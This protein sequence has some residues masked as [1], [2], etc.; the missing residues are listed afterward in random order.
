MSVQDTAREYYNSED[1]DAFYYNIWGGEDIH[2][3]IYFSPDE[4]IRTASRR[5]VERMTAKLTRAI[6]PESHV[7]DMGSGFG[8]A[9]RYLTKTYDCSVTAVNISEVEN[10]RHREMNIEQAVADRIEVIDGSFESVPLEDASV[11]VV[12]S[13]DAI[14][15]SGNR[16]QVVSEVHRVLKPGGEF[17]FTDPMQ[18]DDCPEGV[19]QPILDRIHLDSLASPGYYKQIAEA[20]GLRQLIFEDLT[21]Q[22][23]RHYERVLQETERTADRL[24]GSV[25]PEYIENMRKGLGHWIEGGKQGH[26]AWG[27]FTFKK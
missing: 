26:L 18:A 14:L 27:I 17:V 2:V 25:S 12:W 19:L 4:S 11:D 15:H 9:A 23:T 6:K 16:P 22:L 8:G 20:A 7:L 3:G 13:Q 10:A 24:E 1:A 5:T 21:H